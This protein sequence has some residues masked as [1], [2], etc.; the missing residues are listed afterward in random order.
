[1][2]KGKKVLPLGNK[3]RGLCGHPAMRRIYIIHGDDGRDDNDDGHVNSSCEEE[4]M[5]ETFIV[6]RYTESEDQFVRILHTEV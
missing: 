2:M 4:F 3:L 1:M 5:W 6:V